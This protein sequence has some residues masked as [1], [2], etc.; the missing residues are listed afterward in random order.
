MSVLKKSIA[1]V[2]EE[3][4]VYARALHYL[5]IEFFDNEQKTLSEIC[6]ER[7]I[8]RQKM[9]KCFYDFDN[10]KK[11]SFAELSRYPVDLLLEYLKHSHHLF[12][13]EKLPYISHL[14]DSL[15]ASFASD[16]KEIFPVF[17][18][19]F[20][21]HIYEEEDQLFRYVSSLSK[22]K[23]KKVAN[24]AAELLQYRNFSL[25]KI[26]VE[27]DNE[28]EMGN[29]R[30]LIEGLPSNDLHTRVIIN[31]LKSFDREVLYHAEIENEILFPKAIILEGEIT[32]RMSR[33]SR[34]N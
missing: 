11:C 9:I 21:K 34:M 16:L 12:I 4:F 1:S 26:R 2:I 32:E 33:L 8:S 13:K 6:E 18:E 29:L 28:D 17:V 30:D 20:I 14:L 19:D 15:K 27:H 7:G 24:P 5:G 23:Q 10:S 22:V 3:N 25:E 31:E